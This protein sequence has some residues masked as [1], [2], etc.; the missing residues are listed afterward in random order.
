MNRTGLIMDLKRLDTARSNNIQDREALKEKFREFGKRYGL[1]KPR[2]LRWEKRWEPG[3]GFFN[4]CEDML[5]KGI[6]FDGKCFLDVGCGD[7]LYVIWAAINGAKLAVGLEPLSDGSGTSKKKQDIFP[8]A[9]Y[10]LGLA[11][12]ERLAYKIQDFEYQVEPFDIVLMAASINHLDEQM[13]MELKY[14]IKAKETYLS[15][16]KKLRTLLRTQGKL[17]ITDCSN[18]NL[19]GD[20]GIKNIFARNINWNKH[21]SPK[22]WANLLTSAGF[23]FPKI[24]WEVNHWLHYRGVPKVPWFISYLS[25]SHFR[26][27]MTAI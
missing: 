21:Q 24:T 26:L 17:I 14:N 16:F 2:S 3:I 15:L 4:Y 23:G 5:F 1:W 7:G 9:I 13:C 11:N 18:K 22:L 6:N 10:F 27:E 19:W 8:M 25:T 12:I 20:M